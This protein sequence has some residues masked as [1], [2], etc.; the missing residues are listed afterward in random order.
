MWGRPGT[1]ERKA[2]GE[3]KKTSGEEE[4]G[5]Y[6]GKIKPFQMSCYR[7]EGKK[8][9]TKQKNAVKSEVKN[10]KNTYCE[11]NSIVDNQRVNEHMKKDSCN[12]YTKSPKSPLCNNP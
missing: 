4:G 10:P 1:S 9:R 11:K 8:S 5:D 6:W 7:E 3:E 2:K 12:Q